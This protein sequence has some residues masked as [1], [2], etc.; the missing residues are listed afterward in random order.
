[1]DF[2]KTNT[3]S[4]TENEY[5]WSTPL[6]TT[7]K[8]FILLPKGYYKFNVLSYRKDEYKNSTFSCPTVNIRLLIHNSF[9][10]VVINHKIFLSEGSAPKISAFFASIGMSNLDWE[11]IVGKEGTCRLGQKKLDYKTINIVEHFSEKE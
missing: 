7:E 2:T 6:A 10:E 4:T 1:M 3:E 11:Q 9:G 8:K 5:S